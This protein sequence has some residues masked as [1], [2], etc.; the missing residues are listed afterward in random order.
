MPE[1]QSLI[2][3]KEVRRY[4]LPLMGRVLPTQTRHE[5]REEVFRG[6]LGFW[7]WPLVN[8]LLSMAARMRISVPS[9]APPTYKRRMAVWS[10]S[11]DEKGRIMDIM[12][13]EV[14]E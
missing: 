1:E 13:R 5:A 7:V 14:E 10:V 6:P 3:P 2:S 12:E 11:R 8:L 4:T 9:P